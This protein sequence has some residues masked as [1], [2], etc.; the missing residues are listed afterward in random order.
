M[1]NIHDIWGLIV[2]DRT[3]ILEI[4]HI[5]IDVSNQASNTAIRGFSGTSLGTKLEVKISID[6]IL[7]TV[8]MV[9]PAQIDSPNSVL[10]LQTST[11]TKNRSNY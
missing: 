11:D 1:L 4:L 5:L 10:L 3:G 2:V 8:T 7:D 6:S 9:E